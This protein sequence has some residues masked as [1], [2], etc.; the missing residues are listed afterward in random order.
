MA[1]QVRRAPQQLDA[2]L[3]DPLLEIF[4][5]LAEISREIAETSAFRDDVSVVEGEEGDAKQ[6]EHLE[7]YV[8]LLARR[9]HRL[10]EPWTIEG[11]HAEHVG[12]GPREIVPVTHRWPQML[13]DGLAHHDAGGV[14]VAI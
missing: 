14:V 9:G 11:R 7:G 8:S 6:G 13:G 2:A 1:E 10:G 12:A 4:G 3:F 5:D